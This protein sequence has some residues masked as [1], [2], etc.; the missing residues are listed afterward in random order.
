MKDFCENKFATLD[1]HDVI[2]DNYLNYSL[3]CTSPYGITLVNLMDS[4]IGI[5]K[6]TIEELREYLDEYDKHCKVTMIKKKI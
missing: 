1:I 6:P 3:V 5:T 4:T 2:T